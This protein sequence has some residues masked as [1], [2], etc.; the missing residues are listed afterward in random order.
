MFSEEVDDLKVN[1]AYAARFNRRERSKELQGLRREHSKEVAQ[2]EEH[3]SA[4]EDEDGVL[5]TGDL[6]LQIMRTIDSIKHQRSEVYERDGQFFRHAPDGGRDTKR[7]GGPAVRATRLRDRV[8]RDGAEA[9]L[10]DEEADGDGR[11]APASRHTLAYDAEQSAQRRAFLHSAHSEDEST[12]RR[13]SANGRDSPA[14]ARDGDPSDLLERKP[15]ATSAVEEEYSRWLG[16][17]LKPQRRHRP[18]SDDLDDGR[19]DEN[20]S[21]RRYLHRDDLDATERFLRDYVLHAMWKQ[22]PSSAHGDR[23]TDGHDG[24]ECGAV[25]TSA[26]VDEEDAEEKREDNF[27]RSYNFRFEEAGATQLVGHA[28]YQAHSI[29]R[30]A[31]LGR[32]REAEAARRERWAEQKRQKEL[33]LRRLKNL[34]KQELVE[35]LRTI[36]RTAGSAVP[37]SE[38]DLDGDFDP[39]NFDSRMAQVF[40]RRFYAEEDVGYGSDDGEAS[41]LGSGTRYERGLEFV[42]AASGDPELRDRAQDSLSEYYSLDH[43][44]TLGDDLPTRFKYRKVEPASFGVSDEDLLSL[45]DAQLNKVAPLRVVTMSAAD[46]RTRRAR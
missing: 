29:R 27:E 36:A 4:S 10:S 11:A 34:K 43:E 40:D 13:R 2:T 44:D 24:P 3:S 6:D 7:G 30:Q 45:S 22:P 14:A 38:E 42:A 9:L 12:G 1:E 31:A 35:R 37:I 25:A 5:L 46:R 41:G 15:A 23:A 21:L 28:R 26:I 19:Q 17:R 18:E 32:K 33:E 8:A 39:E 16:E 20:A